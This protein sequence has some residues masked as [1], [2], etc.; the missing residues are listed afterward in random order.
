MWTLALNPESPICCDKKY[1]SRNRIVWTALNSSCTNWI[2]WLL[3]CNL[4]LWT[5][6][7]S[8]GIDHYGNGVTENVLFWFQNFSIFGI[9]IFPCLRQ[10]WKDLSKHLLEIK[11]MHTQ[12][13]LHFIPFSTLVGE[14]FLCKP[15]NIK[16]EAIHNL[17]K[18]S[19]PMMQR[20]L[21]NLTEDDQE[22]WQYNKYKSL[23]RFRNILP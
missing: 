16:P 14:D 11:Q 22:E 3:S 10:S 6:L 19:Y 7:N 1:R 13:V 9:H 23:Q 15:N 2:Y 20:C 4:H 18:D 12:H 17:V 8:I 5:N 21:E